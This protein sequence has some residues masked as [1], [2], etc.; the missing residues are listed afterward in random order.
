MNFSVFPSLRS[1]ILAHSGWLEI[2]FLIISV[3]LIRPHPAHEAHIIPQ[4]RSF[5]QTHS[6]KEM[7]DST[8]KEV[9]KKK[10]HHAMRPRHISSVPA[11]N[12]ISILAQETASSITAST[13]ESQAA[14]QNQIAE[15]S[16]QKP[17]YSGLSVPMIATISST[18][19]V[20]FVLLTVLLAFCLYKRRKRKQKNEITSSESVL[21]SY[22]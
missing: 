3:A 13:S 4:S 17:T 11:H 5:D 10:R 9:L 19:S 1:Q 8:A 21:G 20:A 15:S 16:T 22:S 7:L 14:I 2:L 12:T 6:F 18:A